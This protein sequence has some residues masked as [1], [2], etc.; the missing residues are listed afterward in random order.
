VP[1]HAES[2][3]ASTRVTTSATERELL[4]VEEGMTAAHVELMI[5]RDRQAARLQESRTAFATYRQRRFLWHYG[6]DCSLVFAGRL[7]SEV[8]AMLLQALDRG[9]QWL[10][11]GE[12]FQDVPAD[13]TTASTPALG[14]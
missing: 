10:M 1:F 14:N 2:A 11:R 7:P 13:S 4:E 3:A 9:M 8:V 6:D 12:R 5:K